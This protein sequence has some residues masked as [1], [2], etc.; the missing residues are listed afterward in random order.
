MLRDIAIHIVNSPVLFFGTFFLCRASLWVVVETLW[1]A[2]SVPYRRVAPK[3]FAAELF[4]VFLVIPI[5]IYAYDRLFASFPFPATFQN[6]PLIVRVG[7]YLVA[8]DF[9]YYWL[10]RLMHL[11]ILWR[12]HK[13]H[14]SP[15]YMYWLAGCRATVQ[16]QFLVGIPYVLMT[17][18]LYP[19]PWWVYTA[20]VIF[21]YLLVDWMHLNVHWGTRWFEWVFVTPRYHHIHHSSDARHYD[22]NLGD[23]FTF[24]DRLFGT[25]LDPA[26]VVKQHTNFGIGE[27]LSA[28]RLITG[29]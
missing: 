2:R 26:T 19:A 1:R 16:Q 15:T 9:G 12:V 20:L 24:W 17:P 25:Y 3:D 18:I 4:H 28:A 22:L 23:I 13:W 7:L 10:H 6:L 8:T 5:I 11:P 14:H 21:D 29:L 27:K